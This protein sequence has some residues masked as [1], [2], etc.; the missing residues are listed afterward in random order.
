[1]R[2]FNKRMRLICWW[3]FLHQREAILDCSNWENI[4]HLLHINNVSSLHYGVH[5]VCLIGFINVG[6][7]V[8]AILFCAYALSSPLYSYVSI[9]LSKNFPKSLRACRKHIYTTIGITHNMSWFCFIFSSCEGTIK[10]IDR[11]L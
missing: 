1:M 9:H 5:R 7:C 8:F 6:G 10:H 2:V 4:F 11:E 3:K